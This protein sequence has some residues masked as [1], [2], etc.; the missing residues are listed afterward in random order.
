MDLV[1]IVVLLLLL[2]LL[3]VLVLL[4]KPR[5]SYGDLG[6]RPEVVMQIHGRRR[7]RA[8]APGHGAIRIVD[9]ENIVTN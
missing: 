5:V 1:V 9:L 3:K 2:L 7:L 4:L 6:G 8:S